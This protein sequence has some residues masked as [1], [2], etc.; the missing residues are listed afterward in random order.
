MANKAEV[1]LPA[2]VWSRV[3]VKIKIK[4]EPVDA[5]ARE[6]GI[7]QVL[8]RKTRIRQMWAG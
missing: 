4:F 3:E 7:F 2:E 8:I 6:L 1:Q 5:L